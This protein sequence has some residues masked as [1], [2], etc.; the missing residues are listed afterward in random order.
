MPDATAE[1]L[2]AGKITH[3]P[4][5]DAKPLSTAPNGATLHFFI[6]PMRRYWQPP[7]IQ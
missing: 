3:R 2:A 6:S 5:H 4:E 1:R 7:Q